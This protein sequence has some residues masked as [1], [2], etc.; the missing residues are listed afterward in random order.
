VRW[1]VTLSLLVLAALVAISFSVAAD[2]DEG[3]VR[4]VITI[5]GA[6]T[7][8]DGEVVVSPAGSNVSA[9]I[10]HFSSSEPS[11]S[12]DLPP[13]P[14]TVY[15]W[16]K[17]YHNSARVPF[18]VEANGTTW[19]N[20]TVVRIEELLGAV[21]DPEGGVVPGAVLQFSKDG[22]IV[23]TTTSDDQGR[24]RDLLD[25]GTYQ[26]K[27]TK[28]GYHPLE[29]DVTIEPGQ[30]LD[31][32]LVL[33]PVP[34]EEEDDPLPW[35]ALLTVVFVT[36]AVGLSVG[37]MMRQARKL[38]VAALE[39]EASRSRDLQCPECGGKVPEGENVC[40]GCSYVFQVRCDECGRSMDA[41]TAECPECGA[42]L[43]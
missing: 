26:L 25:P 1:T 40:P 43:E 12:L 15:A 42:A 31:L 33:E 23:G 38:R 24:F 35:I 10:D 41:G 19:V 8:A 6:T 37:Y 18:V 2:E 13:G 22:A 16:A 27:V 36:A 5:V 11:Y 3:T 30:V 28:S 32:D 9:G 17:V 29:R 21:R 7:I 14:Y 34:V 20:L 39:A 4:G